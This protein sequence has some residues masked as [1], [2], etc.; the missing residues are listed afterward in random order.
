MSDLLTV[1]LVGTAKKGA[2]SLPKVP[3]L[4]DLQKSLID[5]SGERV[6]LLQ[7]GVESILDWATYTAD[8]QATFPEPAPTEVLP[9]ISPQATFLVGELLGRVVGDKPL[10][11][12]AGI[13]MHA[14]NCLLPPQ[15][16]PQVLTLSDRELR[17]AFLPVV[18]KRGQWLSQFDKDWQ[19]AMESEISS[20]LPVNELEQCWREGMKSTRLQA[21]SQL[22]RQDPAMARSW[23][24][25]TWGKEKAESRLELLET[26]SINLSNDDIPFLEGL[27][28]DRSANVRSSASDLLCRLQDSALSRQLRE[29]V[30]EL[31]N[32]TPPGK[33]VGAK[34][35][36]L[37]GG[38]ASGKISVTPPSFYEEAWR[39]LGIAEMPPQGMGNRAYWLYEL[40]RRVP[41]S[42]W[43][44]RFACPPAQLV[45]AA[46][47]DTYGSELIQSWT[48]GASS[49]KDS[50]WGHELWKYWLQPQPSE[51]L[52]NKRLRG[53]MLIRVLSTLPS[54][55]MESLILETMKQQSVTDLPLG[56]LL[57]QLPSPWSAGFGKAILSA[58]RKALAQRNQAEAAAGWAAILQQA[59]TALPKECLPEAAAEWLLPDSD[60]YFVRHL[61][62]EIERFLETVHTRLRLYEFIGGS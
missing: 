55:Q 43:T 18:G 31:V 24:A 35:L 9:H 16:L 53:D 26:L 21:L 15:L 4:G 32:Y 1:A 19:W 62:K 58:S 23:L 61:Q 38:K 54:D 30:S 22:R 5:Q 2:A 28:K 7:A 40:V 25:E 39:K 50:E 11:I 49:A 8:R 13:L 51:Q 33:S 34:L 46:K 6:L 17:A 29:W 42:F 47:D 27:E 14:A 37:A 45:D 57:E 60:D 59:A 20:D 48:M 12:E 10:L 56:S 44:Q 36:K 41:T 52:S 3:P